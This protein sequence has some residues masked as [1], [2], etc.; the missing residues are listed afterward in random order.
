[1]SLRTSPPQPRAPRTSPAYPRLLAIGFAVALTACGGA[2]DGPSANA[3]GEINAT[4]A[5]APDAGTAPDADM[6]STPPEPNGGGV[7]GPSWDD[8]GTAAE[9]PRADAQPPEP[10]PPA[11]GGAADASFVPPPPPPPTRDA[12]PT[13]DAAPSDPN[14]AG[15]EPAP[16]NDG[17][18]R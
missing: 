13:K 12:G 16:F 17:G 15:G 6:P 2:V 18:T 8:G 3:T 1:M 11:P 14:T 5:R 9:P 7:L 10:P 4:S